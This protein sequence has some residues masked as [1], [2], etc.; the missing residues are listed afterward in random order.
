VSDID[1]ISPAPI[2]VPSKLPSGDRLQGKIAIVTGA[3]SSGSIPGVG[4]AIAVIL[5]AAGASVVLVDIDQDR[6]AQ[7]DRLVRE[8]GG[9]TRIVCGD[10]T[11]KKDCE[12]VV[13]ETSETFGGLDILV[14][15][16]A[17]YSRETRHN[18]AI[19]DAVLNLNLT[20][21]QR[22]MDASIDLLVARGGGSIINITS[23]AALRGGNAGLAYVASKGGIVA[24]SRSYAN[25]YGSAG[26]R[27]NCIAPGHIHAPMSIASGRDGLDDRELRAHAGMLAS[28]GT[29]WDVAF[30]ALFLASDESRWV[31]AVTLPVDAGMIETMPMAAYLRMHK[32]AESGVAT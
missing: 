31:T 23:A 6:A 14:N 19:W 2:A 15:N 18:E 25:V 13:S 24:L 27:V 5:G 26:I 22:L 20:A 12:R 8:V 10:L 32:V 21:V 30:A 11:L 3:G 7:T 4:S 1:E 29:S 17:L 28:E 9:V 16:A